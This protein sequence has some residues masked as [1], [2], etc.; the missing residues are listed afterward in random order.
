MATRN[1]K[2]IAFTVLT[3]L[4][5]TQIGVARQ[6]IVVFVAGQPGT[7]LEGSSLLVAL[8]LVNMGKV[9]ATRV[10]IT[11]IR[12]RTALLVEPTNLPLRLENVASEGRAIVEAS[13]SSAH[14]VRNEKYLLEVDGKCLVSGRETTY[15]VRRY[16]ELP[17]SA[18][19]SAQLKN[20][21]AIRHQVKGAPFRHMNI[22]IP[23][24]V[25]E[26]GP[27]TPIGMLRGKMMPTSKS[28]NIQRGLKTTPNSPKRRGRGIKQT[29]DGGPRASPSNINVLVPASLDTAP[30]DPANDMVF[31]QNT[32]IGAA[33][34]GIPV[35]PS[36]ASSTGASIPEVILSSGN[37]YGAMST[38]GGNTFTILDPTTIFPNTDASG[39]LIDGGLCC[40]QV[41]HYSASVDRFFWLMLFRAG[42][43]GQNR[44][45]LA[46]ASPAT[47][48]SSGGTSWSYWDLTSS[49]FGIGN[50]ILDYPDLSVGK[51]SLYLSVDGNGGLIV[52]RIP[53]TQLRDSLTIQGGYTDP[54]N[55]QSAYGVHLIQNPWDEIFWAGH[56]TTSSLRVFSMKEGS[57]T[58]SWKDVDID[59][60]P[61][62]DFTSNSPDG[63]N[64]LASLF[65]GG[66]GG[67]RMF[68]A[69]GV[70]Q[71][72][73]E[74]MG[75]RGGNFLQPH[76]QIVRLRTS[77]YKV[78]GQTQIW[79]PDFAFGYASFT[80]ANSLVGVS[81]NFGGGTEY[82]S[83]A[84][85]IFGDEV[86]YSVCDSTANA[87][88]FGDYA[89]VRQAVP[90]GGL[91]SAQVYCVSKGPAF[92]ARYVLFGRSADVNPPPIQLVKATPGN[93]ETSK[94]KGGRVNFGQLS[95]SNYQIDPEKKERR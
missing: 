47:L 40:D 15:S 2:W 93:G 46:S 13:F 91:L 74:W 52:A 82:G 59:S 9:E 73:F 23:H 49:T 55:G 69:A 32:S 28:T 54:S 65:S 11:A 36:V 8:P 45:R 17:P 75:S 92:D 25:N 29:E 34:S 30:Q 89:T 94:G 83:P 62:K 57:N 18:P 81:L 95:L 44:L 21:E 66:P 51:D 63:T 14:L 77:D 71:V 16:I 53:L 50:N 10:E 61:Y 78:L 24:E 35:D 26:P 3:V 38:D 70:D 1:G 90:N 85:G 48:V 19:G 58:Y 68:D 67:I 33:S 86:F 39:N 41:I 87:S 5:L 12:L 27:P 76:I 31:L 43:N 80:L 56:P 6:P 22:A 4:T 72:W 37:T 20:F 7:A 88:R 79:N 60:Y 42:S 84:V 64:W